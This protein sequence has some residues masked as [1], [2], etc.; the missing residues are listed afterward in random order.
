[1]TG[2]FL[3][4]SFLVAVLTSFA[5]VAT[6]LPL[7]ERCYGCP[8]PS[9][10]TYPPKPYPVY[11]NVPN[12]VAC[13]SGVRFNRYQIDQKINSSLTG[14]DVYG[15]YDSITPF[16]LP[17][18]GTSTYSSLTLVCDAQAEDLFQIRFYGDDNQ[19]SVLL[20]K[21]DGTYCGAFTKWNSIDNV[22][23]SGN[24]VSCPDGATSSNDNAD[25]IAPSGYY[26][27]YGKAGS[28]DAYDQP[29]Y[30]CG[31][32]NDGGPGGV[33]VEPPHDDYGNPI[34]QPGYDPCYTD[35]YLEPQK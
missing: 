34:Y 20:V 15:Q 8:P 11:G 4:P 29:P 7:G 30:T 5:F 3:L 19:G 16:Q 23:S 32:T 33:A 17:A 35:G 13:A 24:C 12:A 26:C 31:V 28:S 27:N 18:D 1:M 2:S 21:L 14:T 25:V 9:H 6:S 10:P 22:P